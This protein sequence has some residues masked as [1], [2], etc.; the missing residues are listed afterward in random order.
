MT[1]PNSM[2]LIE[3]WYRRNATYRSDPEL[4]T[5]N[6]HESHVHITNVAV[7]P[8]M[9]TSYDILD[10]VYR[11]MQGENW[12]PQGQA[13]AILRRRGVHHTSMSVGDVAVLE[14]GSAWECAD[15]GWH[16]IGTLDSVP[17]TASYAGK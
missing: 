12:S 11:D 16:R 1:M 7:D 4:S 15:T 8:R 10:K 14:N 13:A 5:L 3:V 2:T 6:L 17:T 9:R